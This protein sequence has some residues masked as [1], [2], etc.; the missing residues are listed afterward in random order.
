MTSTAPKRR[1]QVVSVLLGKPYEE[2]DL[3]ARIQALLPAA[4]AA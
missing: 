3:L 2:D 4:V 1:P